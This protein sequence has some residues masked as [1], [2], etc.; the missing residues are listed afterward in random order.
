LRLEAAFLDRVYELALATEAGGNLP[1]AAVLG[2]GSSLVAEGANRSLVP[3][4]HPGR[5][6][7]IEALRAAPEDVWASAAELTLYTSLE[8][9]LMCFG[10][11]VLHR[12]GRVVFGAADPLGG[13]LSIVPHLPSYVRA[14]AEAITWIGPVQPDRFAPLAQRALDLGARHRTGR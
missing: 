3:V 14:K 2:R 5:H 10:A 11:I 1:V 12:I 4:F 7:E 6:A 13:A 8:P 9:C